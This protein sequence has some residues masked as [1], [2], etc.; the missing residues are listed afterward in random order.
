[1]NKWY[2]F[3]FNI[4]W[5]KKQEQK[6]WVDIFII[7]TIVRDV[8]FQNKSEIIFCRIHRRWAMDEHGHELTFDC[9][10][11]EE[12]AKAIEEL[13]NKSNYFEMLRKGGLLTKDKKLEKVPKDTDSITSITN[14]TG[15]PEQ[16]KEPW[17]C[18]INGCCDMFL[19][20]IKNIKGGKNVPTDIQNA[21]Q[22]YTKVN[23]ELTIIWQYHGSHAFFHHLNAI[24]GYVP[25]LVKPRSFDGILSSF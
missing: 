2:G 6:T 21:E 11:N 9:F 14:D 8:I 12:T 24:F 7:D 16:L 3:N 13:I 15:W 4:S 25:L 5:D 10:T 20:L 18:Y 22:F 19:R 17:L 1:M 23:S